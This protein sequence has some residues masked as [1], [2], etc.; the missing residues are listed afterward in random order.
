MCRFVVSLPSFT[1]NNKLEQ[2]VEY[3]N[4]LNQ[5]QPVAG[6]LDSFAKDYHDYLQTPLQPLLDNLEDGIYQV[7]ESDPVKYQLYED[8]IHR[9]LLDW[10]KER[11]WL[12]D[13]NY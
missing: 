4:H 9:A 7:F 1:S 8:A 12:F 10:K 11:L 3:L 6:L 2:Y 13:I 5:N